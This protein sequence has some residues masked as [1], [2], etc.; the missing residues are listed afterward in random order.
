[1]AAA[2][3]GRYE[4]FHFALMEQPGD[5]KEPHLRAI[6]ER[7]GVDPDRMVADMKSEDIEQALNRNYALAR[8]LGISGTPAMIIGE[9]LVPGAA[10][11]EELQRMITVARSQ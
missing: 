2:K 7:S 11:L 10:E 1:M 6:A 4:A 5:L 9:T 3:Q 8:V